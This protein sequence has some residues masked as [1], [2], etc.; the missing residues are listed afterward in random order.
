MRSIPGAHFFAA[1][2]PSRFN[3]W[4][5]GVRAIAGALADMAA[6]AVR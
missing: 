5:T 6:L 3:R 1:F 4:K 2:A